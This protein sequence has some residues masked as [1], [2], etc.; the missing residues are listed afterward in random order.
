L[1]RFIWA[2]AVLAVLA[3]GRVE[4]AD[5]S[6]DDTARQVGV[7]LLLCADWMQTLDIAE[8]PDRFHEYNP[9]LGEHPSRGRVNM[10]FAAAV[11]GVGVI[12]W[13]LPPKW[14]RW[15]QWGV[16]AV[17]TACVVNNFGHGISL[18]F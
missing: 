18:S 1:E 17:E 12:A 10:Y 14:R 5:W 16:I 4:A 6:R 8:H 13:V 3:A 7:T 2:L 11:V 15:F 9:I